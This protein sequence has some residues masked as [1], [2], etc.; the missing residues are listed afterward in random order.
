MDE[1]AGRRPILHYTQ[2]L[3]AAR[4]MQTAS[5]IMYATK[6]AKGLLPPASADPNHTGMIGY[7]YTPITTTVG[8]LGSKRSTTN[9]DFAAAMVGALGALN[10]KPGTPVLIILSGSFVAGDIGAIVA[11]EA[12]GQKPLTIAAF[13]ASAMGVPP[14]PSSIW[15]TYLSLMHD[16]GVI[17][18]LPIAAVLGGEG[19][20]ADGI[21]P[22]DVAALR[23]TANRVGVPLVENALFPGL[24]DDLLAASPC[25]GRRRPSRGGF[26]RRRRPHRA[27]YMPRILHVSARLDGGNCPVYRGRIWPGDAAGRERPSGATRF[28]HPGTRDR[29]G[30]AMGP[31]SAANAGK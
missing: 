18:S 14:T 15:S 6:A 21:D 9:P 31:H 30:P 25:Q 7:E 3:N 20:I 5:R 4:S 22:K 16:Q 17:H 27:W 11:V 10:L 12:L 8:D 2:M 1:S 29:M 28:E 23:A 19:A 26:E 13:G 24:V